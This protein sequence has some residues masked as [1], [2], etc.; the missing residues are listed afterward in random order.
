MI[1]FFR[2]TLFNVIDKNIIIN[3]ILEPETAS[4]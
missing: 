2:K 3:E 4:K 1:N